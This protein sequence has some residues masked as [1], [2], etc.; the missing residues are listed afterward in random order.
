MTIY[1]FTK[2]SMYPKMWMASGLSY[3]ELIDKL[4]TLAIDKFQKEQRLK[5]AVTFLYEQPVVSD[6]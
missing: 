4:I 6:L 2:I 5:T 3:P 1:G